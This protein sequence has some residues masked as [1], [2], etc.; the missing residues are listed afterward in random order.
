VLKEVARRLRGC[1]RKPDTAARLGGDEFNVIIEHQNI[2]NA[3]IVGE[4]IVNSLSQPIDTPDGVTTIGASIG[5]AFFPGD[6][7][8]EDELLK[9]ADK[10]MYKVKKGAKGA[11]GFA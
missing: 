3:T 5:V 4:R 9:A 6:G 1:I 8:T 11:V 10:A 2:A 7:K